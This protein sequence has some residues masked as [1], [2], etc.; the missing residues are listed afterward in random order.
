MIVLARTVTL[1]MF[2]GF[3]FVDLGISLCKAK[4]CLTAV[5][6]K[7]LYFDD[8]HLSAFGSRVV[9]RENADKME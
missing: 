8:H 3:R 7:P 5:D 1:I 2:Y 9:V 4:L 6:G